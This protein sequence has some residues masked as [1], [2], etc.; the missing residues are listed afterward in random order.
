MGAIAVPPLGVGVFQKAPASAPW[1]SGSCRYP[2]A[3]EDPELGAV[4]SEL[5]AVR[6]EAEVCLRWT[7]PCRA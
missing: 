2:M 3:P 1:H 5:A 4:R 7:N 6:I